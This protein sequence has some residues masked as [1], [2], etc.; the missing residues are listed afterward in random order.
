MAPNRRTRPHLSTLD[1]D[2][3]VLPAYVCT[4]LRICDRAFRKR[5]ANGRIPVTRIG[6]LLRVRAG[7]LLALVRAGVK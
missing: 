2:Q 3:L 5:V 1:P 7:D 6:R 4:T